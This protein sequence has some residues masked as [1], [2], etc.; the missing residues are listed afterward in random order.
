[1]IRV[2]I[3]VGGTHTDLVLID[4]EAGGIFVHKVPST[5]DP[6]VGTIE[7]LAELCRFSG[8]AAADIEYFMHGTTIA[9]NIALEHSGACTGLITTRIAV[10]RR[11][12]A[13]SR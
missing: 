13:I 5:K 11:T 8:I 3:D 12:E 9:T 7:A 6:S 4:E 10:R 1:M 2:G